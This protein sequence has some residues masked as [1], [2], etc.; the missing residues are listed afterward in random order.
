MKKGRKTHKVRGTSTGMVDISRV[1]G[2]RE[3][4]ERMAVDQGGTLIGPDESRTIY[5]CSDGVLLFAQLRLTE[6]PS[7]MLHKL[8]VNEI[9]SLDAELV[10]VWEKLHGRSPMDEVAKVVAQDMG[11][12]LQRQVDVQLMSE[13]GQPL[14]VIHIPREIIERRVGKAPPLVRTQIAV[15]SDGGV[16]VIIAQAPEGHVIIRPSTLSLAELKEAGLT[17]GTRPAADIM[18]ELLHAIGTGLAEKEPAS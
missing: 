17:R 8:K 11:G 15:G 12:H 2:P 13:T 7:I 6:G 10:E 1:Q 18:A 16:L 9:P 5:L 3:V 14:T 4:F